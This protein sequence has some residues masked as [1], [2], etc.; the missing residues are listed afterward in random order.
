MGKSVSFAS[1]VQRKWASG[2]EYDKTICAAITDPF[3]AKIAEFE[4]A[5]LVGVRFYKMITTVS[6]GE[7][8]VRMAT[9][10]LDT[11]ASPDSV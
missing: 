6:T 7:E 11:G 1:F 10:I 5:N 9:E 3:G 8:E 4:K 2:Q